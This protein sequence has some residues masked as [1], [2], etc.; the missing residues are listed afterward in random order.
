MGFANCG[1][2]NLVCGAGDFA[3]ASDA[4][5]GAATACAVCDEISGESARRIEAAQG[6]SADGASRVQNQR[7]RDG[8]QRAALADRGAERQRHFHGRYARRENLY[9]AFARGWERR[10]TKRRISKRTG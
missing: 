4:R 1:V 10:W 2:G 8:L 7:V 9:F 5:A 3:G 6:L